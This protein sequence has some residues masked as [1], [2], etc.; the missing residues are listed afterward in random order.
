MITGNDAHKIN[1]YLPI[2]RTGEGYEWIGPADN[3]EF[4]GFPWGYVAED[5]PPFIQVLRDGKLVAAIN[6][7]DCSE[8]SFV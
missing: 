3:E 2:D 1:G 5:S 4:I 7:L 6:A 8:I